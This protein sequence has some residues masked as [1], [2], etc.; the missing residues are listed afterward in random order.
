MKFKYVLNNGIDVY[1]GGL[2]YVEQI[3]SDD[4]SKLGFHYG[5][6]FTYCSLKNLF[7]FRRKRD[8]DKALNKLTDLYWKT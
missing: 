2:P 6:D 3:T 4:L 5:D 7:L 8:R 1:T